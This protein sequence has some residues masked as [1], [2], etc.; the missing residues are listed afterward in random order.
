LKK[1]LAERKRMPN[2]GSPNKGKRRTAGSFKNIENRGTKRRRPGV[3]TLV[4]LRRETEEQLLNTSKKNKK[5]FFFFIAG[6]KNI[7]TFALPKRKRQSF[8]SK[9]KT[10]HITTNGCDT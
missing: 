5:I 6:R 3:N 4:L 9:R 1:G 7:L 10:I 8:A 2:F